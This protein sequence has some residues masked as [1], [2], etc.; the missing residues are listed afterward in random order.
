MK[1]LASRS[2]GGAYHIVARREAGLRLDRWFRNHFPSLGHG[3]LAKMFRQ[4]Q[5]RLDGARVA[6]GARIVAGQK[7]R[8]PPLPSG[9]LVKPRGRAREM[10]REEDQANLESLLLHRDDSV[11]VL[12]K[13]AGLAVQGGS[14]LR[15]HLDGMLA[16]LR[17]G[18][19]DMPRLAHRLDRDVSGVLVVGRSAWAAARLCEAFRE[20]KVR[21]LYWAL[22]LGVPE[23]PQGVIEIPVVK[24]R[25]VCRGRAR[26][27]AGTSKSACSRYAVIESI[28]SR[29]AWVAFEPE[30]G[31]THQL[32]AHAAA[33]QTPILGDSKYGGREALHLGDDAGLAFGLH[34]HAR[35]LCLPHPDGGT[36][37]ISAPLPAHMVASWQ[38][39]GWNWRKGG[40]SFSLFS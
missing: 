38:A 2:A 10:V 13:P 32:R 12:N 35:R 19:E 24:K 25:V 11:I 14:G 31:R 20:R 6:G 23:P 22:T 16:A 18:S 40:E 7:I 3:R 5:V 21:K 28:T 34:L 39:L 15:C 37:D 8:V 27:T 29:L 36:L 26:M 1:T 30:S 4:G 33:L 17:F 9:V